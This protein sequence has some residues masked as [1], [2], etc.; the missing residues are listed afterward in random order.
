MHH[1]ANCEADPLEAESNWQVNED[2]RRDYEHWGERQERELKQ[3]EKQ[4]GVDRGFLKVCFDKLVQS[5]L[6]GG[7][8]IGN[9]QLGDRH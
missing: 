7:E 6:N 5:G 4:A 1:A 9:Q 3:L 2:S 8:V